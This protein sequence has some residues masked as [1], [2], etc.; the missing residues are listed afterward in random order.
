MRRSGVNHRVKFAERSV[1]PRLVDLMT[2]VLDAH[3]VAG[4]EGGEFLVLDL[5]TH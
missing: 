4:P 5:Q 3:E 2:D 1:L